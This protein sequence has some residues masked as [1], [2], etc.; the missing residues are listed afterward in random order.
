MR[1]EHTL[2]LDIKILLIPATIICHISGAQLLRKNITFDRRNTAACTN[3]LAVRTDI[4]HN[5]IS[6]DPKVNERFGRASWLLLNG[7]HHA[8]LNRALIL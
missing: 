8:E 1:C 5:V 7:S 4:R 3:I 6:T 2:S